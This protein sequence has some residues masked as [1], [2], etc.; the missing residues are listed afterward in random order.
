M[1]IGNG[2]DYTRIWELGMMGGGGGGRIANT[3][4]LY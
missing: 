4:M 3:D 1:G 2:F